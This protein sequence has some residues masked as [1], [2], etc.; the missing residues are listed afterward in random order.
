VQTIIRAHGLHKVVKRRQVKFGISIDAAPITKSLSHVT[1]MLTLIDA[2]DM[3]PR[4]KIP[5][6]LQGKSY[7][8]A[9]ACVLFLIVMLHVTNLIS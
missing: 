6:F 8:E 4:T 7:L 5:F 9:A 1:L 2:G 3:D